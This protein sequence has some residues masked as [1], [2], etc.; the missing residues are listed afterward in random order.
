[1]SN[2]VDGSADSGKL[3]QIKSKRVVFIV[4]EAHR[5]T[6]GTMMIDIKN[7]YKDAVF[8]GFTGT[9]IQTK[10]DNLDSKEVTTADIFGSELH[11][12]T[13]ADGIRDKNVLAFDITKVQTIPAMELRK[14][15]ALDKA[16]AKTIE[17]IADNDEAYAIYQE[18]MNPDLHSMIEIDKNLGN[19]PYETDGHKEKV[20]ENILNSWIELNRKNKFSAIFA[21]SSIKEAI[22]YWR[23]LK[24][25]PRKLK[26]TCIFD[27]SDDFTDFS[28]EKNDG[29]KDIIKHYNDMYGKSFTIP[30]HGSFKSDVSKRLAQKDQYI[31]LKAED[32]IDIVIVVYQLLTGYDSK[33]VSI[34]YLD[35]VLDMHNLIQGFSR[36]NRL[37]GPEKPHGTIRYYRKTSL[38][39]QNIKNAVQ[40]YSGNK[41]YMMYVDKLPE[42]IRSI[43]RRFDEIKDIFRLEGIENFSRVPK[44]IISQEKFVKCFNDL[45]DYL[46]SALTQGFTWDKK[47]YMDKENNAMV[48][49]EMTEDEYNV[50]VLRYQEIDKG[51]GGG[52]AKP[53]LTFN[54]HII[55]ESFKIDYNYMNQN[56]DKFIKIL[57]D[58]N[59]SKEEIRDLK[60]SLHRNF[61][62]LP[63]E[64]QE[65]AEMIINDFENGNLEIREGW[66]FND[67]IN[68]YSISEL[69]KQISELVDFTGID[70]DKLRELLNRKLTKNNLNE[71]GRFDSLVNSAN[72]DLITENLSK[73]KG[74]PVRR[75]KSELYLDEIL[76]KFLREGPFSL[77]D[78][79][80]C[81]KD[82]I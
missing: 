40:E 20:V 8:F 23:L 2:L 5:S 66:D 1:M 50:L 41:P 57:F 36:T 26:V 56:F 46:N 51:G 64:R 27:S 74:K 30:T 39:E 77:K 70:K 49:M 55:E 4:D 47:R 79:N 10:T 63:K 28:I 33:W 68:F 42:N 17:D 71:F 53:N 34:L 19:G 43:N 22:E 13:L 54:Y 78:Y 73:V 81:N 29:L 25:N 76:R 48:D 60:A 6:F 31:G 18:Y 12:Y 62:S 21:T 58:E 24:D 59:S 32:K 75:F 61:A 67:Y 80:E 38:M 3:D 45:Y 35:K 37:N 16:G 65:I 9:P 14:K 44:S 11:R 15:Y 52:G 7:T 72:I 69:D 82:S